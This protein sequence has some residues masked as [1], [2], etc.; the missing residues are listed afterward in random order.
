MQKATISV[1]YHSTKGHTAQVAKLLAEELL[2]DYTEVNLVN[3]SEA[4]SKLEVLHHSDTIVFGCST[5]FGNVTAAFKSFMELTGEFW[6]RQLWKDKLAAG[7]T[8]SSSA[9]GD[10]LNTLQALM[11]FACQ[12][13]MNWISLGILPRFI[14]DEQTD[15]QNRLAT[16]IGLMTQ[17]DHSHTNV[18][19][20]HPGD[21][22]TIELFALRIVELTL[23]YRNI[24]VKN[25]DVSE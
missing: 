12:H 1:V 5:Q 25:Y 4:A 18:G 11:L 20:L 10:K 3:V 23:K 9:S 15:G 7:F 17:C 2:T 8:V 14:N 22:L 21:Q 19:P 24:E 6:Y 13:S 16:Y